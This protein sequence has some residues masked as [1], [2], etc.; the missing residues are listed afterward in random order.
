[1]SQSISKLQG[2]LRVWKNYRNYCINHYSIKGYKLFLED[3][4]HVI[5]KTFNLAFEAVIRN[6]QK[7]AKKSQAEPAGV[8]EDTTADDSDNDNSTSRGEDDIHL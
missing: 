6:C 8:L 7:V 1:M 4:E 5:H 2:N 3:L